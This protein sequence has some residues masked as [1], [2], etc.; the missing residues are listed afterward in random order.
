ML[1]KLTSI[2][3]SRQKA[4]TSDPLQCPI[5][6]DIKNDIITVSGFES[7][8]K[9]LALTNSVLENLFLT[10]NLASI[11]QACQAAIQSTGGNNLDDLL[12]AFTGTQNELYKPSITGA[13]TNT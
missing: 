1:E 9:E 12:S 7:Q 6:I 4:Y 2:A 8:V 10:G 3:T 13:T 11:Q 5:G